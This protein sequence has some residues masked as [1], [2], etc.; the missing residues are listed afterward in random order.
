ML[1]DFLINDNHSDFYKKYYGI[2]T[3]N[4]NIKQKQIQ[5]IVKEFISDDMFNKRNTLI[6]LLICI[7]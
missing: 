6:N 1:K 7:F 2:M 5:L 3:Q 4:N